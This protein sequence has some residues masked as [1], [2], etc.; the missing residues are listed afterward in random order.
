MS[1]RLQLLEE[2]PEAVEA[3]LAHPEQRV[4]AAHLAEVWSPV[5]GAGAEDVGFA[6]HILD[7]EVLPLQGGRGWRW[8]VKNHSE[9]FMSG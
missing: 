5:A 2:Q 1:L 4:G 6:E 7:H 8:G 3:G 9:H